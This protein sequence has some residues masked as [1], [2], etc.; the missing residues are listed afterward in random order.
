MQRMPENSYVM[1]NARIK[2]KSSLSPIRTK[3]MDHNLDK[4]NRGQNNKSK[5]NS[6]SKQ[7]NSNNNKILQNPA[8]KKNNSNNKRVDRK[9]K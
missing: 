5:K 2:P 3:N 4:T 1:D 6:E 8:V 9:Y 7:T